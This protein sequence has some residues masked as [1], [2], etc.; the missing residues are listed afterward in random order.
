[1]KNIRI[2]TLVYEMLVKLGKK[3]K[4]STLKPEV[5]L[6]EMIESAYRDMK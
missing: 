4:P 3:H 1:M 6:E 5:M 2:S